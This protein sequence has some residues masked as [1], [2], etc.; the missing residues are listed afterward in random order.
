MKNVFNVFFFFSNDFKNSTFVED[1]MSVLIG[2]RDDLSPR[3]ACIDTRRRWGG[4]FFQDTMET[5]VSV[6]WEERRRGH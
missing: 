5:H 1:I 3:A 4:I 2:K 6:T